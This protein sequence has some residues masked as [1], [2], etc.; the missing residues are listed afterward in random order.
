MLEQVSACDPIRVAVAVESV[1]FMKMG[2]SNGNGTHKFKFRSIMFNIKDPKN[3]D[4]RRKVL[5]G[6]VKPERLVTMATEEMA[7]IK[8]NVKIKK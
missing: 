8:G 3:P 7:S 5:L 1:M 4:L 6:E 2:K